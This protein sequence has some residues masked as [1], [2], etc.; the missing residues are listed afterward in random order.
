LKN[1]LENIYFITEKYLKRKNLLLFSGKMILE[2]I[3]NKIRRLYEEARDL[4]G[5]LE[6]NIGELRNEIGK[7]RRER[8]ENKVAR[9]EAEMNIIRGALRAYLQRLNIPENEEEHMHNP[10]L[11]LS[12][13]CLQHGNNLQLV[14]IE[15]DTYGGLIKNYIRLVKKVY[16]TKKKLGLDIGDIEDVYYY[17]PSI[18]SQ[19]KKG[20]KYLEKL[21]KLQQYT[22][23]VQREVPV[24]PQQSI[25]P[26]VRFREKLWNFLFSPNPNEPWGG[27]IYKWQEAVGTIVNPLQ[28]KEK[29]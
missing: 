11:L 10:G 19:F 21:I 28:F 6:E 16:K 7:W 15:Y 18:K 25:R 9:Y 13:L 5:E 17:L 23:P 26:Q 22:Q 1:I 4:A 3:K 20:N 29:R 8:R 27:S 2:K 14:K 12:F 24:Q